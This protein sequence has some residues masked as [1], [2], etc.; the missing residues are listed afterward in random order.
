[1]L[2]RRYVICDL[3]LSKFKFKI[4]SVKLQRTLS[5]AFEALY[6]K[7]NA[8]VPLEWI[9]SRALCFQF[10]YISILHFYT[11]I[12]NI[13]V[14]FLWTIKYRL[15][16]KS[17]GKF[18]RISVNTIVIFLLWNF[19]RVRSSLIYGAIYELLSQKIQSFVD[20]VAIQVRKCVERIAVFVSIL[21]FL[22]LVDEK[23]Q[24]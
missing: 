6:H 9:S 12:L 7:R 16:G 13:K 23:R 17:V 4:E 22:Q 21:K 2:G 24:K 20:A 19:Y 11:A 8:T 10:L 18:F 1:M 15:L 3:S 14:W 5:K